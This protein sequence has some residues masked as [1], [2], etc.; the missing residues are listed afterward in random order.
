MTDVP[1][2][3]APRSTNEIAVLKMVRDTRQ[4]QIDEASA[5]IDALQKSADAVLLRFGQYQKLLGKA[6]ITKDQAGL[7]VVEQS[8]SLVVATDASG[9]GSGLG[10]IRQEVDQFIWSASANAITQMAN[11]VHVMEGILA[12][13]PNIW[14]GDA[15]VAGSTFGGSNLASASGA[16]ARAIEMLAAVA[17]YQAGQLGVL[18]SYIGYRTGMDGA[19]SDHERE[20]IR[21]FYRKL[22]ACILGF[23]VAYSG[24]KIIASLAG[25]GK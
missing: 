3:P 4:K 11:S 25:G 19:Q 6:A 20:H 10:L 17:N 23:L 24:P 18:G 1:R 8:S 5:N 15:L 12:A 13:I 7:P 9:A 14:A 2:G 16:T 22:S 21:S